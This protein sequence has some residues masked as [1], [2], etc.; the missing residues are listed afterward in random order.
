LG[1]AELSL[2]WLLWKWKITPVTHNETRLCAI[3]TLLR[4]ETFTVQDLCTASGL[5]RAQVYPLIAE[6]KQRGV[7]C[8][9]PMQ[10]ESSERP[11]HR[12][13]NL[14]RVV[15][16][17]TK[18]RDLS[19]E[20]APFLRILQ[21]ASRGSPGDEYRR[22]CESL[23]AIE[24]QLGAFEER[25]QLFWCNKLALERLQKGLKEARELMELATYETGIH[26]EDIGNEPASDAG[27]PVHD[28]WKRL[29]TYS[30]RYVA[31]EKRILAI[32][33]NRIAEE[34]YSLWLD[35]VAQRR[36]SFPELHTLLA[37]KCRDTDNQ[38]LRRL[39]RSTLD[40]LVESARTNA[41]SS[42]DEWY[43]VCS[44]L[45]SDAIRY[46]ANPM[47]ALRLTLWLLRQDRK[48]SRLWCNFANLSL[49]I[50]KEKQAYRSWCKSIPL[51]APAGSQRETLAR[52][53]Y[54]VALVEI[55]VG[56]L[57]DGLSR[58][59]SVLLERTSLSIVTSRPVDMIGTGAYHI[60]PN[61]FDP[62]EGDN[63]ILLSDSVRSVCRDF[64]VYGPLR[65]KVHAPGASSVR[66]ANALVQIGV[67]IEPAWSVSQDLNDE[68]ALLVLHS[69]EP[70]DDI[71]Q[72]KL[73][74]ALAAVPEAQVVGT[75]Q[76]RHVLAE[77]SGA[78]A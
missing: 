75:F 39:W 13:L 1:I 67:D 38:S 2:R 73:D 41:L 9:V 78:F 46:S 12:P 32:E 11:P 28:A 14:Y 21:R 70:W 76:P 15:A 59:E 7:L 5:E 69:V 4:L 3:T 23:D 37:A 40:K 77:V 25:L 68:H 18:R 64:F 22:A 57:D 29:R 34:N 30:I 71:S 26:L 33:R 49:I 20:I 35:T 62:L 44:V 24:P 61:L 48:N 56:S 36:V 42:A 51:A 6:L 27:R 52:A 66:V 74:S 17:P 72:S 50:G 60:K 55:A 19:N 16:D 47:P 8:I 10:T 65:D 63:T 43:G 45:A 54:F 58:L 53:Y 31:L